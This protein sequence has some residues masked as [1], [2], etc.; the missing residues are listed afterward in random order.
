MNLINIL[1]QLQM[2]ESNHLNKG[3]TKRTQ[4]IQHNHNKINPFHYKTDNKHALTILS[5]RF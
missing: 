2:N 5:S 1:V 4:P 3:I